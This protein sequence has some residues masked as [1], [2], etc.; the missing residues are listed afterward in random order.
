MSIIDK[1]AEK[2]IQQAVEKGE[3][4]DLPGAGKPITLD[5]NALVPEELRAG[6]RLL[7][8]S[9]YLPVELQLHKEIQ[10]VEQLLI[11]VVDADERHLA[12]GKL[13]CLRMRLN[14]CRGEAI[15]FVAEREYQDKLMKQL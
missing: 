1:L 6:Y 8:N 5:D 9:G 15:D 10:E 13:R 7:K 2:Y 14:Q 12:K 11:Q 3:F 4:E